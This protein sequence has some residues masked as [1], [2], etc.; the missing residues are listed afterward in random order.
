MIDLALDEDL[1][2]DFVIVGFLNGDEQALRSMI[3]DPYLLIGGS[4]GG[5]HMAFVCQVS[6]SSHLLAYWVRDKRA[7]TLETA[8]RRLTIFC[9]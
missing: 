9:R 4:D 1:E 3:E 6:Y 8:V 5:A 7:L 2:T